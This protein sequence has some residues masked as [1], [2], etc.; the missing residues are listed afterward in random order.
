MKTPFYCLQKFLRC[1]FIGIHITLPGTIFIFTSARGSVISIRQQNAKHIQDEVRIAEGKVNPSTPNPPASEQGFDNDQRRI[2]I[3]VRNLNHTLAKISKQD[4]SIPKGLSYMPQ[5]Y[6]DIPIQT[7]A[8]ETVTLIIAIYKGI[9]AL[10][11]HVLQEV[12]KLL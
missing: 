8:T 10:S 12:C 3:R 6:K 2:L 7:H 5:N 9:M 4:S 1:C 11:G